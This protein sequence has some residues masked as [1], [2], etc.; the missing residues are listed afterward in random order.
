MSKRKLLACILISV[1]IVGSIFLFRYLAQ[2]ANTLSLTR[3]VQ[4][5]RYENGAAYIRFVDDEV[6][7]VFRGF[8]D[9]PAECLRPLKQGDTV[10]IIVFE[11]Y[12][13]S[14]L[15]SL[16]GVIHNGEELFCSVEHDQ[17]YYQSIPMILAIGLISALLSLLLM[18]LFYPQQE[19]EN[20]GKAFVIGVPFWQRCLMVTFTIAGT[21][22]FLSFWLLYRLGKID[23]EVT[24]YSYIFLLFDS[25]GALGLYAMHREKFVLEDGI[26]TIYKVFKHKQSAHARD[27]RCVKIESKGKYITIALLDREGNKRIHF[28]DDGTVSRD[29]AFL[30][31]LAI[32][33]IPHAT[34]M[35]KCSL[36]NVKHLLIKELPGQF[37]QIAIWLH[38]QEYRIG[39]RADGWV[40]SKYAP[41]GEE[42]M[43]HPS[44]DTLFSTEGPDGIVLKKAWPQ[45][46][47]MELLNPFW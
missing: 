29:R 26:Y 31:S 30:S 25:I 34:P 23:Y 5:I 36:E 20:S 2:P 39:E 6:P 3:Q 7:Y 41:L 11:G 13:N 9:V 21:A 17:M 16:H 22:C 32:Y 37:S 14:E 10:S 24:S 38:G 45:I 35:S 8:R 47:R 28:M 42:E 40:L 12:Q 19:K 4:D 1:L 43:K 15:A 44:L 33:H 18:I 27:I 46:E